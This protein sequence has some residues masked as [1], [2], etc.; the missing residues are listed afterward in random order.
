MKELIMYFLKSSPGVEMS[1]YTP[2]I[3]LTVVLIVGSIVFSKIYNKKKK[4]DLAFKKHFKNV[5]KISIYLGLT[6]GIL[7][8][9]RSENIPYFAMRL[10]L[11]LTI[12]LILAA[13]IW[14]IKVYKT[15]Y[16]KSK[17]RQNKNIASK[18][19]KIYTT[20]KKRR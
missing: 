4:K 5:S 18:P 20:T 9:V 10:W 6:L 2:L 3:A 12:A 15:D 13:T 19:T 14:Y 16:K 17:V 8:L 7:L 1:Y 11:Y